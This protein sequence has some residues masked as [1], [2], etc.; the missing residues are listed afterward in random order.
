MSAG[1]L[2]FTADDGIH[3]RSCGSRTAPRRAPSWSR[4]STPTPTATASPHSLTDVGGTVVLHRRRRHPRRELWKSDGTRAGTV[5]VKDINPGAGVRQRRPS[6]LTEC[7]GQVVLHRRRRHP[8]AGAVEVGRHRAGTVL[9]K[10]INPGA[11][12]QDIRRRPDRCGRNAVLRRRR[13]HPR[14]GAVEVGRH[15]G[16]HRPGQGHQPGRQRSGSR[17]A[18]PGTP[19]RARCGSRSPW[20]GL[21]R[22]PRSAAAAAPRSGHRAQHPRAAGRTTVT[23][24]PTTAGMSKL[25]QSLRRR[26]PARRERRHAQGPSTLHVHPLWRH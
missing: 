1:T 21:W 19:A 8:R 18:A 10:D 17:S 6:Y 15:R 20:P 26:P 4:T 25:R 12:R 11:Q 14:R 16:G 2:F 22:P 23:L 9:V 3:G 5:L 24:T 13:R 7:G